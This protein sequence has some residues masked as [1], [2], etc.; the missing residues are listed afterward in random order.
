VLQSRAGVVNWA[1]EVE[2]PLGEASRRAARA[3]GYQRL[4][5]AIATH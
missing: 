4:V 2:G 3:V 1:G 5:A